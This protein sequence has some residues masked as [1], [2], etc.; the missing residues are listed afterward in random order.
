WSPDGRRLAFVREDE[1][2]GRVVVWDAD[3]DQQTPVGDPYKGRAY[4]APQWDADG[5]RLIVA[6]PVPDEAVK[7][8]RVR[9]VKSTD[10]RIPGD[11]FFTDGRR[12]VLTAID[13]ASG[14]A[15]ALRP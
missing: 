13:A 3:R 5:R 7:P 14:R 6:S 4:L 15:A 8:Y 2:G 11:Q 12:A 10:A 9:V 1:S